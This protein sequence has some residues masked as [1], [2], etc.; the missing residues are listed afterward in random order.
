MD[1]RENFQVTGMTCAACSATVERAVKA[2]PGVKGVSVNLL[3]G[4]MAVDCESA[5]A[6]ESVVSAVQKAGY[7][8]AGEGAPQKES[9]VDAARA[10]A[11]G[12]TR[13]L[14]VSICLLLPLMYIAMGHMLGLPLP[15]ALHG[16]GNE[17]TFALTQFFL[18]VGVVVVN[19]V[20]FK[21]GFQALLRLHPN[22]DSLIA[23]G[24]GASLLYGVVALYAIGAALGHGDAAGAS[25]WSM[26]LYFESAA[27][28]LTLITLG[29]TLEARS[30]GR[31][32]EALTKLMDLAP[33]VAT[34]VRDGAE[35]TIPVEQLRVGDIVAVR[36]GQSLPADGVVV[37]GEAAIDQSAL[38]GESMPVDVRPG[39]AV[40]AATINRTGY[41][42]FRAEK[43]GED[44]A[45]SQVIRLVDEAASSKAPISRLA[46]KISAVFVP[47]VMA[48][49]LLAFAYWLLAGESLSFALTMG[50]SVLVISCPCALGLA[51]PVAIMTGTGR[52]ASL[53]ILFK[54]AEALE[55]SRGINVAVLDKTGTV[56]EG[57]PRATDVLPAEG[58]P[59]ERLLTIAA[60]LEKP[61]EHPLAEAVLSYAR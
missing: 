40:S 21:R 3:T 2:V 29:K 30:K 51:T 8:V 48:I 39:D 17:M 38:T 18:T 25:A 20:F 33:Q 7:D 35:A 61:S 19:R 44:T 24:A 45:L 26:D 31:T 60:S 47:A 42:T 15:A 22:M 28:I 41:I 49:A 52:G 14:I 13:R 59:A 46:D 4:K 34:V 37:S 6:R 11:R 5:T 10:E 50:V 23:I 56:T 54:S 16:A 36:P 27:M 32:S 9:A 1:K 53:G 12:L 58:V 55:R 57:V 43:V